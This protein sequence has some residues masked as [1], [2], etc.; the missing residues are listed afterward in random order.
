MPTF[1]AKK[2]TELYLQYFESQ[3]EADDDEDFVRVPLAS[4]VTICVLD[5]ANLF[6]ACDE[7]ASKS[8]AS[9]TAKS[10]CISV[11]ARSFYNPENLKILLLL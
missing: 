9:K 2:M 8:E 11:A 5:Q 4:L 10:Q 7:E 6:Q 1:Q 3:S